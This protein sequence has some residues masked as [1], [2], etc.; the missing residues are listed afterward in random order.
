MTYLLIAF[1][2]L[3]FVVLAALWCALTSSS[4]IIEELR[5]ALKQ[6]GGEQ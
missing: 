2:L 1:C 6:R 3:Q 5:A 4:E